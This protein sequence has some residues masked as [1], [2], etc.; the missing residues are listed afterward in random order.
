MVL[1]LLAVAFLPRQLLPQGFS[2]PGLLRP[3][4][5]IKPWCWRHIRVR[6]LQTAKVPAG[7]GSIGFAENSGQNM[8]ARSLQWPKIRNG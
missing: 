8:A 5:D 1:R 7:V 6:Q 3:T 4:G 2:F